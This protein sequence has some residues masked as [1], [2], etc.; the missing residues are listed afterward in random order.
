M[1]SVVR[2][3]VSHVHLLLHCNCSL[4][5]SCPPVT[6]GR[7]GRACDISRRFLFV[8]VVGLIMLIASVCALLADWQAEW[9]TVRATLVSRSRKGHRSQL[10]RSCTTTFWFCVLFTSIYQWTSPTA[11]IIIISSSSSSLS[12]PWRRMKWRSL[13]RYTTRSTRST[14]MCVLFGFVRVDDFCNLW[15][16]GAVGR[17]S[18]LGSLCCRFE[19]SWAPLPPR[20]LPLHS[21]T[22]RDNYFGQLKVVVTCLLKTTITKHHQHTAYLQQSTDL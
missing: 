22:S 9:Q 21:L 14:H 8:V 19:F 11:R 15:R 12:R 10:S 6:Y 13:T 17:T 5:M 2:P 7:P 3:S 16:H 20:L 18:D 4:P 1:I